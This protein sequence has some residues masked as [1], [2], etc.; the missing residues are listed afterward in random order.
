MIFPTWLIIPGII[1]V[2]L[3]I[4]F[5]SMNQIYILSWFKDNFFYIFLIAILVF[6]AF[7]L[8][9]LHQNHNIDLSSGEGIA[10]AGKIYLS[11]LVN[12]FKN[13]GKVTGYAVQQDW[14]TLN[15]TNT[16]LPKP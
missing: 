10:S 2:V 8:T 4:L 7:S 5:R 6:F 16:T 12:V 14:S 9:R 13:V 15:I 11:W 1:V 3:I